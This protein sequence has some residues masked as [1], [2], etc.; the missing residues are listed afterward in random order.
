[1]KVTAIGWILVTGTAISIRTKRAPS[2]LSM[3]PR[4]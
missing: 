4:A 2:A 1:M 3:R